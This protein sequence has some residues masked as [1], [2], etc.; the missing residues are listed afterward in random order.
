MFLNPHLQ[1]KLLFFPHLL[2]YDPSAPN[3][4]AFP[5]IGDEVLAKLHRPFWTELSSRFGNIFYLRQASTATHDRQT[6]ELLC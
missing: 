1:V 2:Q 4:M 6:W 3:L 5:Y